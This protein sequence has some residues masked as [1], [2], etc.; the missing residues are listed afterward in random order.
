MSDVVFVCV[1]VLV[2]V[3][4]SVFVSSFFVSFV[5]ATVSVFVDE[6]SVLFLSFPKNILDTKNPASINTTMKTI[7]IAMFVKVSFSSS[8]SSS[9]L[10]AGTFFILFSSSI[11]GLLFSSTYPPRLLGVA[12]SSW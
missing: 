11:F 3:L 12:F 1:L 6:S 4:V 8:S 9:F 5:G 2:F 10:G 7:T